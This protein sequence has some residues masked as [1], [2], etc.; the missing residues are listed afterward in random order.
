MAEFHVIPILGRRNDVPENHPSLFNFVSNNVAMTHDVGGL[1]FDLQ[2]KR[3][4][5]S[6]SYGYS[7]YSA[8]ANAQASKCLGLYQWNDGTR[9]VAI[10]IDNGRFFYYDG[11]LTPTQVDDASA[12]VFASDAEDLYSFVKMG[13]YVVFTD[14]G[15]HPPQKWQYGD[16]N[17]TTLIPGG[18]T[19]AAYTF[20]YIKVFQRR[21]IG[22]YSGATNGDIDVRW[23]E[24]W[25]DTSITNL[26]FPA[27]NQLYIPND[28][29]ITGAET[30]GLDT[31]YIYCG[32]SIQQ[33]VYYP[34]FEVPFQCYTIVPSQGSTGQDSIVNLG[35]RHYLFNKDYGFVEYRGGRDFPYG[36]VSISEKIA[37]DITGMNSLYYN[38]I[39]GTYI[40]LL[41]KCVWLVNL[42]G[43][44][45]P[46]HLLFYDI[47]SGDWTIEDKAMRY[48]STWELSPSYTWNDLVADLGGSS[49]L[50]SAIQ[51]LRTW[52]Y[53]VASRQRLVYGGTDGYLYYQAS[54]ALDTGA[55]DGYRIEPVMD[56]GDPRLMKLFK[57]IWFDIGISGSFSIYVYHRMGQTLGELLTQS[58]TSL[59]T[60][61]CNSPNPPAL[62]NFG[63]TARLHQIKWGTNGANERF[64]VS[65]IIMVYELLSVN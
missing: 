7:K 13:T 64:Q 19:G 42:S 51:A 18:N 14:K 43:E 59:G 57:E 21:I 16:A 48:I 6:K 26:S 23:T 24:S 22:L 20:R 10:Y 62:R 50:W 5:C 2:R 58:W 54:E 60:I 33:L 37:S 27:A 32:N 52:S 1:N 61:S 34:D 36:G 44:S 28:D 65:R 12:T 30:L 49:S 25:P 3:Q 41:R 4:T 40:P 31:F 29:S 8:T 63:K 11:T 38:R 17:L 9:N 56:F 35:D 39:V 46:D 47:L 45:S 15:E 53:Y 55:L